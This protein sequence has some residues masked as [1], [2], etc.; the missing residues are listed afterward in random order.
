MPSASH[1]SFF[2]PW[3]EVCGALRDLMG[4]AG[5]SKDEGEDLVTV[6]KRRSECCCCCCCCCCLVLIEGK[7]RGFRV[8]NA[9]PKNFC[10]RFLEGGQV[11]TL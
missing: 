11:S 9:G 4:F 6:E 10:F 3:K 5:P 7:D 2:F 1:V 8:E